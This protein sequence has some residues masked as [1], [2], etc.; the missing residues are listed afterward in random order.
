MSDET[1]SVASTAVMGGEREAGSHDLHRL[2]G[3]SPPQD[4][5]QS[6]VPWEAQDCFKRLARTYSILAQ[7]AQARADR[8]DPPDLKNDTLLL[9][10]MVAIVR[11]LVEFQDNMPGEKSYED[12]LLPCGIIGAQA[13]FHGLSILHAFVRVISDL[14]LTLLQ[15]AAN[16]RIAPMSLLREALKRIKPDFT[17]PDEL[18]VNVLK[19]IF[20][21]RGLPEEFAQQIQYD[22]NDLN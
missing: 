21:Q 16:S 13:V 1:S 18:T 8:S 14:H 10:I 17:F 9:D 19:Q 11:V 5:A 22:M 2:H 4:P 6:D 20:R 7:A 15:T 12:V 3:S